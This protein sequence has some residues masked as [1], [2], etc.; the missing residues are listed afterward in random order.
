MTAQEN[1]IPYDQL[2]KSLDDL[3][4]AIDLEKPEEVKKILNSCVKLYNSNSQVVDSIYSEEIK[5][6][7]LK[8]ISDQKNNH[9]KVISIK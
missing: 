8:N 1:F 9:S 5:S 7:N 4:I 2:K 3:L 6:K